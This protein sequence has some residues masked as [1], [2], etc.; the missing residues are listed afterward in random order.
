MGGDIDAVDDVIESRE[1]WLLK[2]GRSDSNIVP[3][4]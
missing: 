4:R 3:V 1:P 2:S